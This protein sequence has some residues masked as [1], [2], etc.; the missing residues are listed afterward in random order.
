MSILKIKP[1]SIDTAELFTFANANITSNLVAGNATL[2]NLATSNYFSGNGSLLTSLTGANVTGQVGNALVAGTVYTAAQP[3]ITSTGT[4]TSLTVSGATDLGAVANVKITGGTTGYVLKTDGSGNLTWG[5]AASGTGNANVGGS[6]TQI[7]FNDGTNLSGSANLT[8]DT[9]TNTLTATNFAGN[10]SGLSAIAGANVTGTVANATYAGTANAVAG[11]NVSG[12]VAFAATANAVAG[13]NVS[14]QVGNAL[15][16]GTVYTAAQPA[17]TSVGTLTSLDVTGNVSASY[18]TGNGSLLTGVVASG[19]TA[20]KTANGTSNVNIATANGNVTIGIGGTADVV[21]V[22][23]TGVN[24]TGYITASGNVTGSYVIGNGSALSSIT[25][26]N[27]TGEVAFAATANA[28]AG[29]N[30]TGEVAFAATANAVA[31][32]NV[33]GQVG[34]ALV[35]G[36]VYTAAQPN[37]TSV[38]TL[39]SL[40]VTGSLT[41]GDTTIAGNLTVTGTTTTVNSTVTQIVDPIFEL[42]GGANGAVLSTNDGKERGQLLHYYDGGVKDAFMGW[43]NTDKEFTFAS[44]VSVTDNTVT[45]G[46][47][48]KIK[49]GDAN[50]GNAV[51]SNYFIGN[52]SL[53][54]GVVAS[55]GTATKTANGTSNVDITTANGNI[56][57]AVGGTGNVVIVTATGITTNVVTATSV[58]GNLTTAAQTGITSVGTLTSLAVSGTTNLGAVAN[59]A[60]SGGSADYVLKTD[61]TGNLSWTALSTTTMIV[62]TFTG[63]GSWTMK[64]LAATPASVDYTIVAIG[65]VLQPRSTYSVLAAVITFSEAPPTGAT[66]EITTVTGGTGGSGGGGGGVSYTYS[67]VT[68]NVSMAVAYKYIVD[69]TTANITLTLPATA[70]LGDEISIIDG[71]GNSSTHAITI[72]RNGGKIQGDASDMVVTTDRAAFTLAYYNSTQGWLLTNV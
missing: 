9:T 3:N 64:T 22:T 23:A 24:A 69:T 34:N 33:S 32:A 21:T 35:A 58:A 29:A 37:I 18:F 66:V 26:A 40:A 4:L 17:I 67:E 43:M 31:G 51:T 59:I 14:G 71:T 46:T 6:N 50:L 13:A 11:A 19:G 10:G 7:Q 41:S 1:F 62:D 45:V 61:G 47:L 55:G 39:T 5:A 63:D 28:V 8:F 12:E 53:L 16:A 42:G 65:G 15:V 48:G 49:A 38:G 70:T 25:G 72:A 52:G 27:V 2:G 57:M 30:V 44:N 68:A 56:T 60:I 20:T 36:T 54:T